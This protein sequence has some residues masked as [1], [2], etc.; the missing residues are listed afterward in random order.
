MIDFETAALKNL[1]SKVIVPH[2][3]QTCGK[4]Y[5]VFR[6]ERDKDRPIKACC[7]CQHGDRDY[8]ESFQTAAMLRVR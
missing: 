3:C 4:L 2:T 7:V 6:T 8:R 5:Y 1:Y